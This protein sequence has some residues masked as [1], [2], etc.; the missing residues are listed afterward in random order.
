MVSAVLVQNAEIVRQLE[1]LKRLTAL[2]QALDKDPNTIVYVG[3]DM[4]LL[5]KRTEENI[6]S[7]IKIQTLAMVVGTYGVII[8]ALPLLYLWY[9]KNI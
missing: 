7:K 6:E 9:N 2:D 5:L 1:E 4:E 8:L 3:D